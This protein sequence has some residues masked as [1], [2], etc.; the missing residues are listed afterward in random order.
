MKFQPNLNQIMKLIVIS[1]LGE[2]FE[3]AVARE[4][5]EEVGAAVQPGSVRYIASQ[6]S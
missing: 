3:D 1:N 5:M 6:V 2:T 4:V